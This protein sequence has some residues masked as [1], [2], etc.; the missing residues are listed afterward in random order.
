[1]EKHYEGEN[2]ILKNNEPRQNFT[3]FYKKSVETLDENSNSVEYQ[4]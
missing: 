3:G 4:S 1:M 2:F